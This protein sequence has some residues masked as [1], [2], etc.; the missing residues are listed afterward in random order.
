[1]NGPVV[2]SARL[3]ALRVAPV[4]AEDIHE[5]ANWLCQFWIGK[6]KRLLLAGWRPGR[7][8]FD[9]PSLAVPFTLGDGCGRVSRPSPFGR[10]SFD[11]PGLLWV[12]VGHVLR[13]P[14]A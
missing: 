6:L 4:V 14:S 13:P 10:E 8:A 7:A 12:L 5:A 1:M 2:A 9:R 11:F 3:T